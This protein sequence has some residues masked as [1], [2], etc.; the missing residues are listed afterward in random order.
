MPQLL[1]ILLLLVSCGPLHRRREVSPPAPSLSERRELYLQLNAAHQDSNGFIL[2]RHC[3][4][5]LFSSLNAVG[6]GEKINILAARDEA[7]QWFRRP[8]NLPECYANGKS[9][10]TISRDMLIGL[11]LYLQHFRESTLVADL[12][13]YGS[14]N[15]WIMGEGD[16]VNQVATIMSPSLIKVLAEMNY[17][18]NNIDSV[19]RA[20]PDLTIFTQAGGYANHLNLLYLHLYGQVYGGLSSLQYSELIRYTNEIDSGNILG[21]ILLSKYTHVNFN[22]NLLDIYPATRLPTTADWCEDWYPQRDS[23]DPNLRPCG[24][25][26]PGS[27]D[28]IQHTGGDFLFLTKVLTE[29]VRRPVA[30]LVL[31]GTPRV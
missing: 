22:N 14:E 21:Q 8:L 1:L 31:G 11:L 2:V 20:L 26:I 27:P 17:Q 12:W 28:E 25:G 23:T 13:N 10:S 29:S 4:S 5:L 18:M 30:G 15:N 9:K 6:R 7:G 3:D 24:T 16:G 19:E